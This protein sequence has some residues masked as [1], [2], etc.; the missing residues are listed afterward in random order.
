M[1][2]ILQPVLC[3]RL[4]PMWRIKMHRIR[5]G[6]WFS[7]CSHIHP[8]LH[9]YRQRRSPFEALQ[10]CPHWRRKYCNGQLKRKNSKEELL[11]RVV[12]FHIDKLQ[13]NLC[14][15]KKSRGI[16]MSPETTAQSS[17]APIE[18]ASRWLIRLVFS[19]VLTMSNR[20]D[21]IE[22]FHTNVIV[23]VLSVSSGDF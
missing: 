22:V 14:E 2:I 18:F 16:Q 3:S 15:V 21:T 1:W 19:R 17:L 13:G 6:M 11:I 20:I 7:V 5:V 10:L 12:T 4:T 9:S 23:Q 8:L